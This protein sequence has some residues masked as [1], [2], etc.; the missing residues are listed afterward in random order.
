MRSNG[1]L[2][3]M[4]LGVIALV[5]VAPAASTNAAHAGD[6]GNL[7]YLALGDSLAAGY[8]PNGATSQGYVDD[9][10]RS[11]QQQIPGLRL[12]NVGCPGE[13]T[14]SMIT[15]KHSPCHYTAGSQ[16][17]AAVS[18]L[19]GHPGQVAFITIDIGSNDLF[20]RCVDFDVGRLDRA[21]TVD[22]LPRRQARLT[23]IVDALRAA[24]GPD[25]PI[26]GMT[27]YNPLLGFWG[28]VPGGRALA[29][30]N[31]RAWAVF[32]AGLAT[33]YGDAGAAVADVAATFRIDDFTDTVVVPGRGRLPV[34]VALACGWTWF[35]STKFAG[36]PHANRKGYRKIA[37]TFY[38]ELQGLLPV[39]VARGDRSQGS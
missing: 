27:Y 15:G 12:R 7:S 33:A 17:D 1:L 31:Q 29:R 35:C 6:G 3:M 18:F 2:T 5:V 25:V 14:G 28:L 21:C 24:A 38:Q 36:D 22:L 39:P 16:L 20:D 13:T 8:Q 4:V 19:E 26:V 32:N 34:N 23:Y 30:A 37:D 11:M 9:L 10:W